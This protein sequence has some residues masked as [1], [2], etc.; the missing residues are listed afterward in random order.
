MKTNNW[1]QKFDG[2]YIKPHE[3]TPFGDAWEKDAEDIKRFIESLL[4]EQ[5]KEWGEK[6]FKFQMEK[7]ETLETSNVTSQAEKSGMLAVCIYI[8]KTLLQ[9]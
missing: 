3:G 5:K 2:Y 8:R 6:I 1:R 7:V 4:T 9:E